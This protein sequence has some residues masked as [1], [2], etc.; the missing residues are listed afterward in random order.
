MA[1]FQNSSQSMNEYTNFDIELLKNE[2]GQRFTFY[3][4]KYNFNTVVFFCT[5]DEETLE[6]KFNS[7]RLSLSKEGYIPKI[8][9]EKGEHKLF[10]IKKQKT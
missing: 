1:N 2:V 3:D 6:E 7:L 9:Y 4:I 8:S 10:I 5:I